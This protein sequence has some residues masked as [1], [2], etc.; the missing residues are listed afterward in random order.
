MI[1]LRNQPVWLHFFLFFLQK[2]F[3]PASAKGLCWL[4]KNASEVI[5]KHPHFNGNSFRHI[6]L[7]FHYISFIYRM[8]KK[9]KN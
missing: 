1:A 6:K 2:T 5:R 9:K 7:T 4:N 8:M 3:V